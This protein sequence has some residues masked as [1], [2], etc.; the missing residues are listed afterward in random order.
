ML[1]LYKIV[2][3]TGAPIYFAGKRAAR[4]ALEG[5]RE[6]GMEGVLMR[7]PDH[8]KGESF[9]D[10]KQVPTRQSKKYG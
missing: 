3:G 4:H 1:K 2:D 10:S 8:W 7:G 5:V 9:N 6:V